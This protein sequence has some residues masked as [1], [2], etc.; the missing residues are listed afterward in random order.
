MEK[1]IPSEAGQE[2]PL[3]ITGKEDCPPEDSGGPGIY[4]V[5]RRQQTVV[6][7]AEAF[8]P[9]EVNRLF[10]GLRNGWFPKAGHVQ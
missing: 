3:C 1:V 4:S 2:Y 8:A 10:R 7:D 6:T 9:E 5:R